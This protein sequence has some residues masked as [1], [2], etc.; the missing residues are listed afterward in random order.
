MGIYTYTHAHT[1]THTCIYTRSD[2]VGE[3][4]RTTPTHPFRL[5]CFV[6][7]PAAGNKLIYLLSCHKSTNTDVLLPCYKV[8]IL[9]Y[10]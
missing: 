2:A 8:Q 3:T 1:H 5:A 10:C 7:V 9:T 4:Y 6:V